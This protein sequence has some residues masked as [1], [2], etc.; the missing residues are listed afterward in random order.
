MATASEEWV[1]PFSIRNFRIEFALDKQGRLVLHHIDEDIAD[2]IKEMAFPIVWNAECKLQRESG[3]YT[4]S[5]R[6]KLAKAVSEEEDRV[7]W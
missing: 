4:K 5:D 3:K 7:V 2:V 6:A 1:Q